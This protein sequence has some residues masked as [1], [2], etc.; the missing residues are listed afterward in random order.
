MLTPRQNP[1]NRNQGKPGH[2]LI[3]PGEF[4]FGYPGQEG[5]ADDDPRK[6]F[7]K[8]GPVSTAGVDWADDGPCFA[9]R[10]EA[11]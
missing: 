1:N 5:N 4:V 2:E 10:P 3:W 8:P 11:P 9:L 6:S 7:E